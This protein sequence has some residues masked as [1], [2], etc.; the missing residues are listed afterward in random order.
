[1]SA[2]VCFQHYSACFAGEQLPQLENSVLS[3]LLVEHFF[4]EAQQNLLVQCVV[5][6]SITFDHFVFV[7]KNVAT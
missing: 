3:L 4:V 1:V 6:V 2:D 7:L 5:V